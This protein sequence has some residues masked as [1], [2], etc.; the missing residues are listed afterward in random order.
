[1]GMA[2]CHLEILGGMSICKF[3]QSPSLFPRTDYSAHP[4]TFLPLWSSN[5][6]AAP[7]Q[8]TS[9][10]TG[11]SCLRRSMAYINNGRNI[12]VLWDI[13]HISSGFPANTNANF[14]ANFNHITKATAK[15]GTDSYIHKS[16]DQYH[17]EHPALVAREVG[18]LSFDIRLG[19]RLH[20][21][22]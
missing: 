1:M 7:Y 15:I 20:F 9:S 11:R 14:N 16:E 5:C 17:L 19:G 12:E 8:P 2:R 6:T 4:G 21:G 18:E 3:S 13:E 22:A 10:A